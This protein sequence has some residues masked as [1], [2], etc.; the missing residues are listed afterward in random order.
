MSLIVQKYGGTSVANPER[1]KNVAD[2]ILKTKKQ[3][4][5]IV[6]VVSALA[7]ITDSLLALASQ[8]S[9]Q[10][11]ER[12]LDLLLATGE[13][14]S[15]ALLAMAI[16]AKGHKAIAFTGHQLGIV[17]DCSHT[18]ARIA[19]IETSRVRKALKD[20]YIVIAA[21]FQ[22]R[23]HDNEIT[24]L[25]R[26]GSDLTAVALAAAL[27]AE[28]C[29][30][31]TDVDGIYT[32]DPRVVKQARKLDCISYDEML[33]LAS[34]G[35]KV[36]QSRSVEVGKKY[37]VPIHVRSSL[38]YHRGTIIQK[39]VKSM[40]DIVVRGVALHLG[41][42]KVTIIGIPDKPGTAAKIFKKLADRNVNVDMIIQNNIKTGTT[43]ISFTVFKNEL[44]K[45]LDA[46]KEAA[47]AVK[48]EGV[49]CDPHIAKV[50]IVGVGMRSHSGVASK[51]FGALASNKINIEMISTSEIK[52][53]CVVHEKDGK[54]AVQVI[55]KAF[56]L[57]QKKGKK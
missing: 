39:E 1:I 34:L 35:A 10:P 53:S 17:T 33:E 25:G 11:S 27:K 16:H 49:D 37:N 42:A 54:K 32:T 29:E 36:M 12:E 46:V 7:G 56:G 38:N 14:V 18:K 26:G 19:N 6:A 3:G 48:A 13:Q 51:T 41:E 55:H 15:I 4:K 45:S 31:Y 52:I 44:K 22:G 50:S 57:S 23:S 5:S 20:G 43:D 8:V 2:R 21:G 9:N 40:E 30:I 28:M 24:T 47:R